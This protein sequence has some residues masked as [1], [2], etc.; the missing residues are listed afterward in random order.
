[1]PNRWPFELLFVG[2]GLVFVVA[3]H[4]RVAADLISCV[5]KICP[6][7]RSETQS[8]RPPFPS[9]ATLA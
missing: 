8:G 1:M 5:Y 2:K 7:L 3:E 4:F 6:I 9:L